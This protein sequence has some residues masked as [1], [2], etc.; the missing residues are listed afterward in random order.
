MKRRKKPVNEHVPECER[1]I[2]F[3]G[4]RQAGK[5]SMNVERITLDTNI[6]IYAIDH[7]AGERHEIS[8]EIVDRAPLSDCILTLQCLSEFYAAATRKGKMPISEAQAQVNDWMLLFPIAAATTTSLTSAIK[9]VENHSLSFWDAMLWSVARE[10]GVNC[11]VSE[12]FQHGRVL[13]GVQ[14]CNPFELDEPLAFIFDD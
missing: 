8:M 5:P 7:D 3:T 13:E 11:L 10:A 12:D 6:L 1:D 4:R 9:A 14:F 2:P